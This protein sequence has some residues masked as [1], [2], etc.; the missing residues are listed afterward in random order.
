M[1]K[2][3]IYFLSGLSL[4]ALS[5]CDKDSDL[6]NSGEFEYMIFGT[7]AGECGG[8][9]CIEI[10]KLDNEHLFEDSTDVYPGQEHPYDGVYVQLPDEK[11]Q[12]VKDLVDAFPSELYAEPE[13]VI[14]MPDAGDWGGAYV[15]MKFKNDPGRSGFWLL[16]QLDQNMPQVYNEFVDRINEKVTL[17]HE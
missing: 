5:A 7:F 16:D 1:K 14:G 2:V 4:V 17:I 13:T 12:L 15:E 11:F 3:A 9:G 6:A 8:E 10:F